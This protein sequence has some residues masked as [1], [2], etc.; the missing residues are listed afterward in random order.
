[1]TM[2]I[3][4]IGSCFLILVAALVS[5]AQPAR[6]QGASGAPFEKRCGWF[7]NPTP[8]NAWLDDRDGEW[9][10]GV[11]GGW[12]ADGDWPDFKPEEWVR[13]NGNYGYGCACL[14]VRVNRTS[15]QVLE[16]KSATARPLKACRAD[17]SLKE[18]K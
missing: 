9:I 15:H 13:T 16:I 8:G 7:S 3:R 4:V 1:M 5:A 6:S 18:P 10:I 11:Q 12:Q 2:N 17:R 14:R